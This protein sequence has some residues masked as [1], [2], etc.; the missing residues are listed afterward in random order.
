MQGPLLVEIFGVYINENITLNDIHLEHFLFPNNIGRYGYEK[1]FGE[2]LPVVLTKPCLDFGR[3]LIL[4]KTECVYYHSTSL[5]NNMQNSV[6]VVWKDGK[7][8]VFKIIY[9]S[10]FQKSKT[11]WY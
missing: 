1:Y 11:V 9:V 4:P 3:G 6:E 2:N 10:H 8:I 7:N 5:V